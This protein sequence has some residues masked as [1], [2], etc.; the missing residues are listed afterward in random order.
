MHRVRLR[1]KGRVQGVFFRASAKETAMN[2]GITGWVKN[3]PDGTVETVAEGEQ[4]ELDRFIEWCREG[5][6]NASVA[7]VEVD[8]QEATGEFDTF[9]IKH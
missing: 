1:I 7:D 4:E 5:P 6:E 8:R 2:L 3:Q 9:T